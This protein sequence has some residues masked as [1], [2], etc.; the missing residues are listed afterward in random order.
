MGMWDPLNLMMNMASAK[1]DICSPFTEVHTNF[2]PILSSDNSKPSHT[3][4]HHE[5]LTSVR[6]GKGS[7]PCLQF[8]YHLC[9]M[10]VPQEYWQFTIFVN[11]TLQCL[12]ASCNISYMENIST[13]SQ[14]RF[15]QN[16]R[17]QE[18]EEK[19]VILMADV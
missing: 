2:P 3:K 14:Q 7:E 18:L 12:L 4:S 11:T 1:L 16:P 10:W 17:S 5:L 13:P 8:Q 9:L 6:A 15:L 19:C